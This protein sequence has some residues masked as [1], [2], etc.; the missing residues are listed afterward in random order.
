[1]NSFSRYIECLRFKYGGKVTRVANWLIKLSTYRTRLCLKATGPIGVLVDNTVLSNA[2]P[3]KTAW[4]PTGEKFW[5]NQMVK[6]EYSAR[7]SCEE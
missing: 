7:I 5:G 6:T 1:M 2:T 3:H 4:V